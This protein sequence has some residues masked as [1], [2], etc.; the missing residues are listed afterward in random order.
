MPQPFYRGRRGARGADLYSL[1]RGWNLLRVLRV[2]RVS[3]SDRLPSQ[4][5][6]PPGVILYAETAAKMFCVS[7]RL[8]ADFTSDRNE[9][10]GWFPEPGT[11]RASRRRG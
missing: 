7:E 6:D 1:N 3:R 8:A 9:T 2:L 10:T 4:R 5:V 11:Q